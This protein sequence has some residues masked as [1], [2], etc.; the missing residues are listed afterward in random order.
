V[1]I[2][3]ATELIAA[4]AHCSANQEEVMAS[5]QCGC[6]HCL[7]I[8]GPKEITEWLQL[9]GAGKTAFC[10]HCFIDAVLGSRSGYSITPEFLASMKR[11]WFERGQKQG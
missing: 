3:V 11:Q 2:V 10:P 4:H 1:L 6:F 8:F 7:R 5:D 9:D